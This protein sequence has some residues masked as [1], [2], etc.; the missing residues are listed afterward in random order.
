AVHCNGEPAAVEVSLEC[1]RHAIAYLISYDTA[2]AKHGLGIIVAEHSIRTA[3]EQGFVHFDLLTPADPYKMQW[4]DGSV[5]V[6][7][8]ALPLSPAGRLYVR[9]WLCFVHRW[10]KRAAQRSPAWL[11]RL[12]IYFVGRISRAN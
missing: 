3:H 10:L 7:D 1:K 11:R 2:L 8:W 6:G 4:A 9:V 12:L 5:E